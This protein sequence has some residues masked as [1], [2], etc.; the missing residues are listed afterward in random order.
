MDKFQQIV[1]AIKSGKNVMSCGNRV[2]AEDIDYRWQEPK[3]RVQLRNG[4]S[5]PLDGR[6]LSNAEIID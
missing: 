2:V 5:Y 1:D 3:L 6:E 4:A